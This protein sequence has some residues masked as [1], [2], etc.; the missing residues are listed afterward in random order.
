MYGHLVDSLTGRPLQTMPQFL[1]CVP[2]SSEQLGIGE[3]RMYLYKSNTIYD[4]PTAWSEELPKSRTKTA[5]SLTVWRE[6]KTFPSC[7]GTLNQEEQ[8]HWLCRSEQKTFLIIDTR[9]A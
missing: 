9:S 7:C 3:C 1:C 8:Q 6:E 5:L 4:V 2:I